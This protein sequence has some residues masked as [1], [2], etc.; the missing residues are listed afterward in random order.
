MPEQ[1]NNS[2]LDEDKATGPII[3]FQIAWFVISG[4]K[5][6][7]HFTRNKL[8][9]E[10]KCRRVQHLMLWRRVKKEAWLAIMKWGQ[11]GQMSPS[12]LERCPR[13]PGPDPLAVFLLH[14]SRNHTGEHG[15]GEEVNTSSTITHTDLGQAY[16]DHEY[17]LSFPQR[18]EMGR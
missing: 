16:L 9:A 14:L 4:G 5:G 18:W 10:R 11:C 13:R 2:N 17:N 7:V 12:V 8:V 15:S 3:R 1:L 6:K